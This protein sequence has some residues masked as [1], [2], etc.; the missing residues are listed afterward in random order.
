MNNFDLDL[1]LNNNTKALFWP[2]PID[3]PLSVEETLIKKLIMAIN[4]PCHL[5]ETWETLAGKGS[6]GKS[7]EK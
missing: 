7:I 2:L 5:S 3:K 6:G 4:K 1:Y